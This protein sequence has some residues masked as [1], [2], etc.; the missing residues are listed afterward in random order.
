MNGLISIDNLSLRPISDELLALNE[1]SR[2]YG[3]TLTAE[4][5]RELS[6][7]RKT[8][9]VENE[10]IEAGVGAVPAILKKFCTSRYVNK[11]NYTYVLNEVTYLFYYIKT[12]TDD[13]IGDEALIDELFERFELYCRGSIDVLEGREAERIIRKVNAGRHY[14]EWYGDR[15]ELDGDPRDRLEANR[16]TPE[17]LLDDTFGGDHFRDDTPADHDLYEAEEDPASILDEEDDADPYDD[18]GDAASDDGLDLYEQIGNDVLEDDDPENPLNQGGTLDVR[19]GDSAMQLSV[20]GGPLPYE[21]E[22]GDVDL[23]LFD[24][25][26]DL[27]AEMQEDGRLPILPREDGEDDGDD[28]DFDM[29]DEDYGGDEGEDYDYDGED[30][31]ERH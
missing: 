19:F 3:L 28:E 26:F 13:K 24:K 12:E 22:D 1:V 4:E 31:D 10:R 8:A 14:A 25:F 21:D 27:Q 2:E 17:N 23:D 20:G 5:A 29:Y 18:F 9:L 15:D 11:D 6:E 7:T 30:D 16:A